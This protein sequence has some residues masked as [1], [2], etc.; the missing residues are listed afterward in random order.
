[1]LSEIYFQAVL[2]IIKQ[3]IPKALNANKEFIPSRKHHK[4]EISIL[5]NLESDSFRPMP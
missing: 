2:N 3:L 4:G 1:M 5:K